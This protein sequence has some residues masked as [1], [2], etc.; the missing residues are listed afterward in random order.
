MDQSVHP[1]KAYRT[2]ENVKLDELAVRLSTSKA[3]LSRIENRLQQV[4]EDLLPRIVAET[5][6]SAAELRPDLAEY[7]R[8][9][10]AAE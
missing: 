9:P 7:F 1:I 8:Q 10:E 3:N 6:I 2:R 4:S 5:G